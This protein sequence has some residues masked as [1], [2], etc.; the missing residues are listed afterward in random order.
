MAHRHKMK[1]AGGGKADYYEGGGSEVAKE[2]AEKKK[3]GAVHKM[4]GG[5]AKPRL[6]KRARGGRANATSSPFSS[7]KMTEKGNL[8]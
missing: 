6:D 1:K 7:A 4:H 5:A 3:G 8:T 2:A